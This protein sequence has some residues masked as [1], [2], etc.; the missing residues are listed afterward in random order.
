MKLTTAIMQIPPGFTPQEAVT[1]PNN[2][3]TIFHAATADLSLSLQWPLPSPPSPPEAE[4]PILIWGGASSCGQYALQILSHWGYRNLLATASPQ[5]HSY[6]RSLG[7][8]H[9]F[10]YRDPDIVGRI[11]KAVESPSSGPSIPYILDCIG[12]KSASVTPISKIAQK[13]SRVAVLLPVILKDATEQEAPEYSMEVEASA[14]WVDGVEVR[15]VRTHFYMNVSQM[16]DSVG[17]MF[18][19]VRY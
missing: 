16:F 18:V 12:S 19:G 3:V 7:A 14:D 13:G 9:V 2:V 4:S 1:L 5:H 15:G 10:D 8:K 11:V 6:L 17:I